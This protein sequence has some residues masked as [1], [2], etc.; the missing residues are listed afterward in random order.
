MKCPICHTDNNKTANFCNECGFDLKNH[1]HINATA[2]NLL[3]P[4]TH[5][6][7]TDNVPTPSV[8]SEGGPFHFYLASG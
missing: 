4:Y 3:K 5:K 6:F 8:S 2:G 1:K 7:S